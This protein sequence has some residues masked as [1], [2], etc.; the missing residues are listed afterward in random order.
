MDPA[1]KYEWYGI[2]NERFY[3]IQVKTTE[4]DEK[5]Q[6]CVSYGKIG[7]KTTRL[8]KIH[9]SDTKAIQHFNKTVKSKERDQ[10]RSY[11]KCDFQQECLQECL[12]GRE[13]IDIN[14][15]KTIPRNTNEKK[16]PEKTEV[17]DDGAGG[18]DTSGEDASGADASV[19]DR[20]DN[21]SNLDGKKYNWGEI[22]KEEYYYDE[23]GME[24]K[25]DINT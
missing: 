14:N 25:R 1:Y 9:L 16:T 4:M 21:V 20:I 6:T 8:T 23:W 18:R 5:S 17:G 19:D 15:K 7:G 11:T 10:F 2:K 13:K 22:Q 12:R 3:S 24:I